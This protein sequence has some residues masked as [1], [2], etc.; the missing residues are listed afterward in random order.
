[1]RPPA[2]PLAGKEAGGTRA[3]SGTTRRQMGM[4]NG[5]RGWNTQPGG[6]AS[7]EGGLPLMHCSRRRVEVEARQAAQQSPG[8]RVERLIEDRVHRALLHDVPGVHDQDVVA[9]LGDDA[10][11][12]RDQDDRRVELGPQL[13]R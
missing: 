10:Q 7:S 12:V 3:S 6:G 13:C 11:V 2:S 1:M 4:T 8:V 5:Q 9:H